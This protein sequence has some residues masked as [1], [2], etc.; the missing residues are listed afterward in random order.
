MAA[1]RNGIAVSSA[2][3]NKLTSAPYNFSILVDLRGLFTSDT[4]VYGYLYRNYWSQVTHRLLICLNPTAHIGVLRDFASAMGTA[5]VW[6]DP[7]VAGEKTLL[8]KFLADLPPGT[9]VTMGWWPE[10]VRQSFDDFTRS[11]KKFSNTVRIL[12]GI[13]RWSYRQTTLFS[14]SA[15]S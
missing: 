10:D 15:E 2:L 9:G 5:V 7:R 4:A 6:L 14:F 13:C 8:D 1:L 12:T 11:S 3:V